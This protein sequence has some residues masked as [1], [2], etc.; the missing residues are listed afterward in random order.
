M[1]SHLVIAG[2]QHRSLKERRLVGDPATTGFGDHDV[3]PGTA[4]MGHGGHLIPWSD[5]LRRRNIRR[6]RSISTFLE[7]PVNHETLSIVVIF[8]AH[9]D[10]VF[11]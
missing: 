6:H 10:D 2:N 5:L 1:L 4:G 8:F 9:R 7:T 3:G 11:V